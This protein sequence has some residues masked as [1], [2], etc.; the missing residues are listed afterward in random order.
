MVGVSAIAIA[1]WA[2]KWDRVFALF[3]IFHI[4]LIV[5]YAWLVIGHG[6]SPRLPPTLTEA[7]AYFATFLGNFAYWPDW[8]LPVGLI[9]VALCA[10]LFCWLTWGSFRRGAPPAGEVVILAAFALFMI[11]EAAAATLGRAKFGVSQARELRY[12]T[13][14]LLLVATLFALAWR[15]FPKRVSR[16][17]TLLAL[18]AVLFVANNSFVENGWRKR[19]QEMDVMAAEIAKGTLPPGA[20]A[21]L[22]VPANIFF[23]PLIW[24]FRASELGP[25]RPHPTTSN[26]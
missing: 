3:L 6:Y 1:V 19:N 18:T 23:E 22:Y 17:S 21:T 14:T 20:A 26:P 8:A 4:T 9:V 11:L 15:L 7:I 24:R 13:C 16:I 5:L 12:T 25:F 10:G 2:R